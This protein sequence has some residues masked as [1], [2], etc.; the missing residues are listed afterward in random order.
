MPG[1]GNTK[2]LLSLGVIHHGWS[3]KSIEKLIGDETMKEK[4]EQMTVIIVDFLS[5]F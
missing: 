3:T 2:Y 5:A 4:R 1:G